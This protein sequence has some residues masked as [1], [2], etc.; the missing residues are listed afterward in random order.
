[1]NTDD[2]KSFI[3]VAQT[4]SFSATADALYL[5]QPAVSKR[6]AS[7][8]EKLGA[9]LFDRIGRRISLTEAGRALLPHARNI[10]TEL[11]DG[12]RA[13]ANLAQGRL[14]GSLAMATSHHIGLHRLPQILRAYA[15]RYPD[16]ELD[17]SF[18][19]SEQACRTIERGELELAVITLPSNTRGE[20]THIPL[21]DDPL[22]LVFSPKHPLPESPRISLP[23]L[24]RLP[25]IL[26][27][28]GSYTRK[29]IDDAFRTQELTPRVKIATH[30]L[31]TIKMLVSVG[32]GW[33]VLPE[34]MLD[35]SLHIRPC[36][37]LRLSRTLGVVHH[38]QRTLSNA[39]RAMIDTCREHAHSDK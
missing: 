28:R 21:W 39:A 8:E 15:A 13:I 36:P 3:S 1:M 18:L 7:L 32:L 5:T 20:L 37:E 2:L 31:E 9:R 6:I 14:K 4:G 34:T 16:V 30:N 12:R 24:S 17:L 29:L 33:S 19:D 25:A 26:P 22:S 10:L 23:T 35:D 38:P 11:E 27:A